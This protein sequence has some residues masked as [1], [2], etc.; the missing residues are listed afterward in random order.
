[1]RPG[2]ITIEIWPGDKTANDFFLMYKFF[3]PSL[4]DAASVNHLY[5]S[6]SFSTT[7]ICQEWE[8]KMRIAYGCGVTVVIEMWEIFLTKVM[9]YYPFLLS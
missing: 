1:M 2:T 3:F 6:G 9:L 4:A 7:T 8:F 5:Y